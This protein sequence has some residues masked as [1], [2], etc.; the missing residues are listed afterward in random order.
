MIKIYLKYLDKLKDQ[1][2]IHIIHVDL[3]H[4]QIKLRKHVTA[5]KSKAKM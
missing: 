2:V 5:V 4:L 3:Q 1:S